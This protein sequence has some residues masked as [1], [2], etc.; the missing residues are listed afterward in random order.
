MFNRLRI[1][2]FCIC[3]CTWFLFLTV[4]ETN[5]RMYYNSYSYSL[6]GAISCVQMCGCYNVRG[7][8]FVLV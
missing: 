6:E 7:I 1:V 8:Y 5:K 2:S 3:F 4:H